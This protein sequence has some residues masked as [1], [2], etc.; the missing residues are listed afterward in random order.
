MNRHF[1][2]ALTTG[3]LSALWAWAAVALGLPSWAGFLGCTAWFASPKGGV[4]GFLTIL[5]T[6]GSGVLWAQV[7]I[8]GSA[9]APGI[10]WL[11]YAM[12]GVVAFLMCI[13][14]RQTLL[15]F[16]PGTFIGAC[17][18]FAAQG[19]WKSVLPALLLGLLFGVAM[20]ASGQ[21]LAGRAAPEST[22]VAE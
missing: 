16:V 9:V 7:I 14:S 18:T 19:D 20:K 3:L 17:A 22:T 11:S 10:A 12:T 4:T 1:S 15:S 8:A 13:Q 2:L 5:F 6:L 21:W